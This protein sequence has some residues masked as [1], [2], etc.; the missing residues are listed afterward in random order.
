MRNKILK[1]IIFLV[2][3]L[4]CIA[5]GREELETVLFPHAP[6]QF[7]GIAPDLDPT[8]MRFE[9]HCGVNVGALTAGIGKI[10]QTEPGN[11]IAGQCINTTELISGFS[12]KEIIIDSEFW[13]IAE[14]E[15]RKEWV[16]LH[17]LGH[18]I[19]NRDH[20]DE[21]LSPFVPK[22]IMVSMAPGLAH[23]LL[24]DGNDYEYYMNEL[25][26]GDQDLL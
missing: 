21:M 6:R 17:E 15:F 8:V 11:R 2:I 16:I 1:T 12:S 13:S 18:C 26:F 9:A 4:A 25:C 22:S 24:E 23:K 7:K 5:C 10:E 19:L 20:D 14:S 3:A